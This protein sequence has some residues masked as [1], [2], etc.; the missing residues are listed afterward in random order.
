MKVVPCSCC[1][2]LSFCQIFHEKFIEKFIN[3]RRKVYFIV[4]ILSAFF[5]WT[6]CDFI[7]HKHKCLKER[8]T[9]KHRESTFIKNN[10]WRV[11]FRVHCFRTYRGKLFFLKYAD[12]KK[13]ERGKQFSQPRRKQFEIY[14]LQWESLC[15][16]LLSPFAC[17]L[18]RI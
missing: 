13:E 1:R 14:K 2:L 15:F 18:L 8:E 5:C 10:L 11:A 16:S 7:H 17:S 4:D 9:S 12:Y 3:R 6:L